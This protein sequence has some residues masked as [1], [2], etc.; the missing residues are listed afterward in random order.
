MFGC[1]ASTYAD[2]WIEVPAV[3]QRSAGTSRLGPFRTRAAAQEVNGRLF[4]GRAQITGSDSGGSQPGSSGP[5]AEEIAAQQRRARAHDL[6][7]EGVEHCNDRDWQAAIDAFNAALELAP[8]DQTIRDNL[9]KA[10]D[11]QQRA[12]Q[13][14]QRQN[15]A[16]ASRRQADF[17]RT[18]QEALNGMR[19][20]SDTSP[21]LRGLNDGNGSGLRGVGGSN[22]N[23]LGLKG[24]D[25][26]LSQL[27][28][29]A[30]TSQAAAKSPV[31]EDASAKARLGFDTSRTP[32]PVPLDNTNATPAL[33]RSQDA[34]ANRTQSPAAEI[35]EYL[36][37]GSA[38][39]SPYPETSTRPF[40]GN[41]EHP[42]LNP[43][44]EEA[45]MQ[46][47][48]KAWDAWVRRRATEVRA[49]P[50]DQLLPA[51]TERAALNASTV[52]Q[53]APE[54][55]D[56]YNTDTAYRRQIDQRL[57]DITARAALDYYQGLADVH[58]TAIMKFEAERKKLAD[59]GKLDLLVPLLD[60]V[61]QH[62]ERNALI[63]SVVDQVAADEKAA[64]ARAK[65]DGLGKLDEQYQSLFQ[66]IRGEAAPKQ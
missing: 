3:A 5:S 6:N 30:E 41:P 46:E 44:R 34:T 10:T 1:T 57:A 64:L 65:V 2:W 27:K 12:D 33:L 18:R 8:G 11:A 61:R 58:K 29:T 42:W 19:G 7:E 26:S 24:L 16:E 60:Q 48:I 35:K 59:A 39:T 63:Q 17:N 49:Q 50:T 22:A 53:F 14:Q 47:Q 52:R 45:N 51:A 56:R 23:A 31:L 25:G 66:S 38:D 54:L 37:P 21:G 20:I 15:Q 13:E 62:P 28:K 9:D 40:P 43:L 36:F 32:P 4:Q 55:F